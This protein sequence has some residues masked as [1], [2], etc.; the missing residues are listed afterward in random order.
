MLPVP[1]LGAEARFPVGPMAVAALLKAPVVL[2]FGLWLGPRRYEL[3]FEPF[4]ERVELPRATRDA[5]LGVWL[6]RY[7]AR[8][9]E[10]CRA[11]PYNWFNFYDFW[12]EEE[13]A[14]APG[15]SRPAAPPPSDP[16]G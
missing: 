6:G 2:G 15:C 14:R 16:H 12:G 5:A 7:T 8:L 13:G 11:H 3:R 1:F 4:A 9:S 10:V